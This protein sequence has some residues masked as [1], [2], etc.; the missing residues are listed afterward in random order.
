MFSRTTL[1]LR[2]PEGKDLIEDFWTTIKSYN[3]RK[4]S[5]YQEFD[6]FHPNFCAVSIFWTSRR[7][8]FSFL[9]IP[10]IW[11]DRS[12]PWAD[13]CIMIPPE[14]ELHLFI[15]FWQ[16]HSRW[17][18][19]EKHIGNLHHLTLLPVPGIFTRWVKWKSSEK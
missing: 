8:S 18:H 2:E 16:G 13:P 14:F 4:F 3:L 19:Y 9:L 12:D 6:S 17:K 15:I 7:T 10:Q 11:V 5:G 1:F